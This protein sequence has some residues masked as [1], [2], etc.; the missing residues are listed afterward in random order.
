LFPQVGSSVSKC[1]QRTFENRS[2]EDNAISALLSRE[3]RRAAGGDQ[4]NV[5]P[6]QQTDRLGT[7][8]AEQFKWKESP[9]GDDALVV[10][11][12]AF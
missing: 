3:L 6:V 12:D 4:E 2:S 9:A 8:D 10:N 1:K 11:E 5:P 7:Q